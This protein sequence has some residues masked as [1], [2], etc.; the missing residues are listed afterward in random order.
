[1][2]KAET[3]RQYRLREG[4]DMPTLKLARILY[5]ENKLLFKNIEEARWVLRSIENKTGSKQAILV[6]NARTEPR[7]LNPY[8]LPESDAKDKKPYKIVGYKRALIIADLHIPYHDIKAISLCFDY[9]VKEKPDL[10]IINGDLIDCYQLSRFVRN[11]NNRNFASELECMK[12]FFESLQN[13]FPKAKIVYKFGNH[14]LRYEHFLYTK[15]KELDGVEEIEFKNIIQARAKGIDLVDDKTIIMLNKLPIVHGHEFGK[16]VF[17]PVNT[18]RG[19]FLRGIH[20]CLQSHT[21][22][23]SKHSEPNMFKKKIV[24]WSLGCL[25]GLY[26]DYAIMNKWE[27]GFAM[28]DLDENKINFEVRLKDISEGKVF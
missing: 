25:C 15:A 3:A 1:M 13:T 24:T 28:V 4:N 22:R 11:P 12:K 17:N 2:T 14:E 18:A 10:I 16:S 6:E 26:P 20:T 21:H 27:H 8:K 19:L 7:P 5:N 9:A 23:P